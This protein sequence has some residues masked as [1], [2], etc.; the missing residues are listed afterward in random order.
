LGDLY[1]Y[2][3]IHDQLLRLCH[4]NS[5][6]YLHRAQLALILILA[7]HC[8]AQ[9]MQGVVTQGTTLGTT[10]ILL[11]GTMGGVFNGFAPTMTLGTLQGNN[12]SA[13]P[14]NGNSLPTGC[15]KNFN[16]LTD[17]ATQNGDGQYV[18]PGPPSTAAATN[19][20]T[21]TPVAT[22]N[23]VSTVSI[24]K[25]LYPGFSGTV[26]TKVACHYQP[27]FG[28][29]SHINIG[30]DESN[31]AVVTRQAQ[32]MID[33]GCKIIIGDWYGSTDFTN[34][35]MLLWR[36]EL[37]SR[38]SGGTC[39]LLMA[40]MEDGG[41]VSGRTISGFE[42]DL[43]YVRTNY[44]GHA[45]YWKVT[46]GA[47]CANRPVFIDFG[48]TGT[49]SSSDW[50]TIKTYIHNTLGLTCTNEPVLGSEGEAGLSDANQDGGY[51]WI[52]VNNYDN[53][54]SG[55]VTTQGLS[56]TVQFDPHF[57][58]GGFGTDSWYS[59]ANLHP[60]QPVVI[61]SVYKGFDDTNA[62]WGF[63]SPHTQGRKMAEQCGQVWVQSFNRLDRHGQILQRSADSGSR[64]CDLERLRRRV[65]RR[66]GD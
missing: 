13:C 39:P 52:G 36:A 58:S 64:N 6:V 26:T 32:A 20:Q 1:Q 9:I 65:G 43:S 44:F 59:V 61:G 42:T 5:G 45:S 16:G 14:P 41:T 28:T 40:I 31:A 49:F 51:N 18:Y 37:D 60:L 33:R 4:W 46:D 54:S 62:D 2:N 50:G 8:E 10:A 55:T 12:T 66:A 17:H 22:P 3:L 21:T 56:G 7:T 57:L 25:L 23:N 24:N 53:A 35:V 19:T 38:C 48:W 15:S 34:T 47:G 27:W 29:G 11:G 63:G 30:M